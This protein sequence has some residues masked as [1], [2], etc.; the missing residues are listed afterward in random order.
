MEEDGDVEALGVVVMWGP[1][2]GEEKRSRD[3]VAGEA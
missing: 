1:L 3:G 2:Q